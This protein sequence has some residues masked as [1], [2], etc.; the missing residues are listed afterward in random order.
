MLASCLRLGWRV[1]KYDI[2]MKEDG[3]ML[4]LTITCPMQ[5]RLHA[6]Q[7]LR[8]S[9]ASSSSLAVRLGGPPD[10]EP[11]SDYLASK[12]MAWSPAAGSLRALGEGGWWT[13]SRLFGEGKAAD[14][15]CKACGDRAGLGPVEGTLHHRMSSCD[16]TRKAR[17]SFKSQ[18]LLQKAQSA[19]HGGEPLFQ[20]G[21]PVLR[22]APAV[23]H[24]EVRCCGGRH[25]PADFTAT[26]NAFTDGAMRGRAPRS[27]R[28][29][30][31]AWVIVDD[32]GQVIF[33]LYGPCPDPFPTAFRAELRAVCELLII[34][35][36]PLTIWIDNK[37][38]L[39]GWSK[40]KQW[41]CSSS[42]SA[43]DL[44]TT[45]WNKIDDIG[46][47]GIVLQKTKG[48]ATEVD[49]Q[50]GRC[51]AF[52][53]AGNDH[54]DHLAGRGVD[55][56]ISHAPNQSAIDS[57]KEATKW[58]RWLTLLCANWPADVDPRP[59]REDTSL[60][61][62]SENSGKQRVLGSL[63]FTGQSEEVPSTLDFSKENAIAA[64]NQDLP[65]PL[66]LLNEMAI[67]KRALHRSHCLKL[68]GS[69]VWCKLCGAYADQRV[70]AVKKP[71]R[72]PEKVR[73]KAG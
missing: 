52:A 62:S 60:I 16:A 17:E 61:I 23:P 4:D 31:W 70:K 41:C 56:A 18:E 42:R 25:Q 57:Y 26:G 15:W 22:E 43:A 5:I 39:D 3:V 38:V 63:A 34:A 40:G 67:Q 9:E 6:L 21:V 20:H 50:L 13:Q 54:A 10:L 69:L 14:P 27:A 72:G 65:T 49:V 59:K 58:Y 51:S 37:E 48:H 55:V 53:R 29:A 33:G 66:V 35:V 19:V 2:I 11:L 12:K 44:W 1:P 36:P 73:S 24:Q 30:G 47:D 68:S 8:R 7:S 32:D 28:R 64:R 46:A 45:F 71:C